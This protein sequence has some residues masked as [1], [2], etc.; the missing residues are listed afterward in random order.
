MFVVQDIHCW[1]IV[2]YRHDEYGIY[3]MG[4][5]NNFSM[6]YVGDSDSL[7]WAMDTNTLIYNH[8]LRKGRVFG[9]L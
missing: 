1:H 7:L 9:K 6:N 8:M 5:L 2:V 4:N 3:C